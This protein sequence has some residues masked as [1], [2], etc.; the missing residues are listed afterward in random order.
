MIEVLLNEY[1]YIGQIVFFI[2]LIIAVTAFIISWF[3]KN[4]ATKNYVTSEI[5]DIACRTAKI[6]NK[7][8]E[9][10]KE[11]HKLKDQILAKVKED[12][13]PMSQ[14]Q[15]FTTKM[16]TVLSTL[17][18]IKKTL[19]DMTEENKSILVQLAK[20]EASRGVKND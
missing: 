17:D 7:L 10:C 4:V 19:N 15:S 18:G 1:G 9:A 12:Y 2:G 14:A 11:K 16:E 3:Y 5:S 13:F 20:L 6:S 8:D